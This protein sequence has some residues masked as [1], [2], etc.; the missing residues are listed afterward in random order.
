MPELKHISSHG[1]GPV[2]FKSSKILILG[3]F[4]SVK[5]REENFFYMHSQ[6]RFWEI[7]SRL[8]NDKDFANQKIKSKIQALKKHNIALYDVIES[9]DIV[10]SED[11]SITNVR[12]TNIEKLI[13]DTKINRIFLNG[14]KAYNLFNKYNPNLKELGS[15]LPSTSSANARYSIK[16]LLNEW[17]LLIK[18]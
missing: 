15:Y 4:P 14:K 10:N 3:S 1:F 8:F 2:I 17:E 13:K 16:R 18:Q 7:L 9:C 5:S 6:N 12:P 11:S